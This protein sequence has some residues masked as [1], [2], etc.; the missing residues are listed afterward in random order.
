MGSGDQEYISELKARAEELSIQDR[1]IYKEFVPKERLHEYYSAS[2]VGIWPVQPSITIIEAIGCHLPVILPDRDTVAHLV[3][4]GNGVLFKEGDA[5]NLAQLL[6]ELS[7]QL[8]YMREKAKYAA[9]EIFDYRKITS[10]II[11]I[12]QLHAK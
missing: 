10:Q 3:Q 8:Q 2:D 7:G 9:A 4:L 5:E 6:D 11:G 1:F 12:A